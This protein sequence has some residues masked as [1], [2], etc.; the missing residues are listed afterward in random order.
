VKRVNVSLLPPLEAS[1]TSGMKAA[2]NGADQVSIM[3]GWWLVDCLY[4]HSMLIFCQQTI[5]LKVSGFS[6]PR[7]ALKSVY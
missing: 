2:L 6:W 4:P 5:P 3:D 7:I 1:G